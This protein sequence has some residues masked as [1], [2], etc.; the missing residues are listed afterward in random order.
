MV[1]REGMLLAAGGAVTGLALALVVTQFLRGLLYE[2]D[3]LD[4]VS[5]LMATMLLLAAA[6]VACYLP[7]RT[8]ARMDP[9]VALREV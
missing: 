5:L 8:A 2:V 7:A 6:G 3:P 9:L 1:L 4:A